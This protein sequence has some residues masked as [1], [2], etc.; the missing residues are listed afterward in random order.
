MGVYQRA[1]ALDCDATIHAGEC[2][3]A[4]IYTSQHTARP[5]RPGA[6]M[7]ARC[8]FSESLNESTLQVSPGAPPGIGAGS[9]DGRA[10]DSSAAESWLS[11]QVLRCVPSSTILSPQRF[12]PTAGCAAV[13]CCVPAV[14][15]ICDALPR[16]G[17]SRRRCRCAGAAAR[18]LDMES[19]RVASS[20]RGRAALPSVPRRAADVRAGGCVRGLSRTSCAR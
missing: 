13:R 17:A 8:I 9:D 3:R 12:L 10:R 6:P 19:V 15:P 2:A 18:L 16:R 4:S 7:R 1:R 14:L 20:S 11:A 5:K